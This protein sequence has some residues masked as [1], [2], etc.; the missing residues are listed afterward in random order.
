MSGSEVMEL[1]VRELGYEK[2]LPTTVAM[3]FTMPEAN[4]RVPCRHASGTT[5]NLSDPERALKIQR[6]LC[7]TNP[8]ELS[9]LIL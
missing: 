3:Q 1:A 8:I 7:C 2:L 6:I 9:I 4:L 5:P